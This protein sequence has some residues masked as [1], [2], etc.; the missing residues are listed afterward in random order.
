[1][2]ASPDGLQGKCKD[3]AA[4]YKRGWSYGLNENGYRALVKAQGQLCGIC[5]K[6]KALVVDHNHTTDKIRGLLCRECN[7]ALGLF[8]DNI[9]FIRSAE[10]WLIHD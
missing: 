7:I 9:T 1:M 4:D 2:T 6:P 3:C 8:E 10:G 5:H